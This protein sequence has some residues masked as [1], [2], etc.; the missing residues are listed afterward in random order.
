MPLV[1]PA[2]KKDRVFITIN[3]RVARLKIVPG[4]V[5]GIIAQ[6]ARVHGVR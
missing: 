5:I 2:G 3:D 1:S 6:A 4:N